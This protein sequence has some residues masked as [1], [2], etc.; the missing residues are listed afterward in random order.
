MNRQRLRR[1]Y[2]G[3]RLGF[4]KPAYASDGMYLFGKN[5][6]SLFDD[7]FQKAYMKGV[8]SGH[9]I[10]RIPTKLDIRFRVATALWAAKQASLIEGDFVECGVNTGIISRAICY[11]LDFAKLPKRFYLFDTFEGIPLAS[12]STPEEEEHV[13]RHNQVYFDCF[14]LV[15]RNFIEFTNVELVKGIIP[16]SLAQVDIKKVAFLSIDLN[17]AAPEEAALRHF[18]P[19]M[20]PG[21]VVVLDDYAFCGYEAQHEVANIFAAEMQVPILTLPTGQGVIVK[22]H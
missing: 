14:E 21:A 5:L 16:E 13:T 20:V 12:A 7:E 19:R 18:W 1:I 11:H 10:S 3:I 22:P 2:D 15:K 8:D 4:G 17:V 9:R 6:N